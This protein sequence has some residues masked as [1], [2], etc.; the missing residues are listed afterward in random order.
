MA[1]VNSSIDTEVDINHPIIHKIGIADLRDALAKGI[2]DFVAM[3]THSIFVIVIY[4][5]MGLILLRLSF[6]YDMLPVVFPLLAGFALL[7]P[8]SAIGLYEMSRRREEGQPQSWQVDALSLLRIR[9]I[10]VLGIVLMVIFLAWLSAAMTI[11]QSTFGNWYPSSIG[12]FLSRIFTTSAGWT[13][14]LVGFG[15]G[16]AFALLTFTI[17]VVSFPMLVD[18]NVGA[19]VAVATSIRAVAANPVTMAVWGLIVAIAL[20]I[21]SLPVLVGLAVVLPV[22]GHSTWHLYRK[23]VQ[24]NGAPQW[25]SGPHLVPEN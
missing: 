12:E 3:P 20:V 15:V 6:G 10:L 21:G 5:V 25:Q 18:R 19:G 11:Y 23:L 24:R 22:L 17:S 1:A 2:D 16:F 4:P 9:P 14:I 13:L 8:F 7:G